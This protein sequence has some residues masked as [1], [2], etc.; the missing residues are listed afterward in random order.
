MRSSR[1]LLQTVLLTSL[2]NWGFAATFTVTTTADSGA[3]SLRQA[4]LDANA[5]VGVPDVI[6]F[7]IPPSDPGHVYYREDGQVGLPGGN[8]VT[9]TTE[10]DDANLD[11]PDQLYPRSWYRIAPVSPLPDIVD[12]VVIDGYTQ[13]GASPNSRTI[14]EGLNT[15]LRVELYG[16][17]AGFA[18]SGFILAPGSEGSTIRGFA[19]RDFSGSDGQPGQGILIASDNNTIEGNFLGPGVDGL[20]RSNNTHGIHTFASGNTI[21]G[22]TPAARNLISGNNRYGM[23]INVNSD[24]NTIAGNIVGLNR[25]GNG[26]GNFRDGVLIL[27]SPN[28]VIGG[29][30][31]GARNIISGNAWG[32]LAIVN[33]PATGN[34]VEGNFI[35]VNLAG[36]MEIR[37]SF[38]GVIC[39]DAPGNVIGGP[40]NGQGNVISGNGF[41]GVTLE[42]SNNCLIQ[43]NFIGTDQSGALAIPNGFSGV[44]VVD[45]SFSVIG[46]NGNGAN[47]IAFNTKDG[48]II[49]QNSL[50]NEISGNAIY[51]NGGL[52]I[53]L[54][55]VLGGNATA[56]GPTANDAGDFDAGPNNLQNFPVLTSA[57][58]NGGLSVTYSV[59][60]APANSVYPITVEFFVADTD[61]QEGRT[62]LGSDVYNSGGQKVAVLPLKGTVSPGAQILATATDADGNTSEFSAPVS[63]G[64][65]VTQRIFTVNSTGDSPDQNPLDGVCNTGNLVNGDPECTLCAA[66]QQAN[67]IANAGSDTPD[68]IHFAIPSNDPGHLYYTDDGIAGQ[69]TLSS[70]ATATVDS[71]GLIIGIDPDWSDSWY[72]IRLESPLPAIT[73]AVVIDGHTQAGAAANSNPA[74]QGL[75]GALRI[76]IDGSQAGEADEGL[77]RSSGGGAVIRGLVIN[78]A[79]GSAVQFDTAGGN[80]IEGCY[81]GPDISGTELFPPPDGPIRIIPRAGVRILSNENVVG[82]TSP[83]ARNLISGGRGHGV[84]IGDLGEAPMGNLVQGNLIGTDRTGT[85]A[86]PNNANG[87]TIERGAQN[88][89]GGETEGAGNLI[90]GNT[91]AGVHLGF[92][93]NSQV[94]ENEVK[95]NR[96][97]TTVNGDSALG[98][99]SDGILIEDA[100]MNRIDENRIAFNTGAG[101]LIENGS[102]NILTRNSLFSNGQIGIDL[103]NEVEL[104]RINLPQD[105]GDG[106]DGANNGQNFPWLESVTAIAG[107]VV[108]GRLNSAPSSSYRLEFFA[109]RGRD[110]LG[111]GEGEHY[112]GSLDVA[113][114]VSGNVEFT[115]NLPAAPEGFDFVSATATDLTDR[116][117]GPANDTSEFSGALPIGGCS[118]VVS[119]TADSG[120]G[121]LREAIYCANSLPDIQT[122]EFS[123][124]GAGPHLIKPQ[125]ALPAILDPVVI[126]GYTQ[127]GSSPNTNP[128]GQG[129]NTVLQVHIDGENAGD[130]ASGLRISGG[131][132]RIQGLSI[133]GFDD[134]GLHLSDHGGNV[135]AGSFL[136]ANPDGSGMGSETGVF[137][138]MSPNNV[139]GGSSAS[140]RN[141]ISGNGTGV[142]TD[143]GPSGDGVAGT[144]IEGNLI[145]TDASGAGPLGNGVGVLAGGS[146]VTV[147][148]NTVA[149]NLGAGIVVQPEMVRRPPSLE[150][151]IV[152]NSIYSNEEL[153]VDIE[154][155]GVTP[156]DY[157]PPHDADDGSNSRQNFPELLSR[158]DG[159]T[160]RIEGQ[161]RSTPNTNFRI[162]FF[163]NE[164]TDLT[165]F[166]EG[167]TFLTFLDVATDANGTAPIDFDLGVAVPV[168]RSVTST[169][170]RKDAQGMPIETSEFSSR[171]GGPDGCSLVV[172]NTNPSGDGSLRDA[173][174]CANLNAGLDT[175]TFNIPGPGPHTIRPTG[176]QPTILD[177]VIID[178][179]TQPGAAPNTDPDGFNGVVLIELDGSEAE[180]GSTGLIL[181][182]EGCIIRGLA[183]GGFIGEV[184]ISGEFIFGGAGIAIEGGS[185]CMIQGNLLGTDSTGLIARPNS[186]GAG[187][188]FQETG[189]KNL[190]GGTNPEDRNIISGNEFSGVLLQ[191]NNGVGAIVQGNFIGTDRTGRSPLGNGESAVF[192]NLDANN[193]IGGAEPGAGNVL[194]SSTFGGVDIGGLESTGNRVEGNFIGTDLSRT[195]SLGNQFGGVTVYDGATGN[196]IVANTISFNEEIGIDLDYDGVTLND[197]PPDSVPP[198]QDAGSNNLQNFPVISAVSSSAKTTTV[199]GIL[200]STP[201]TTFR[202]DFFTS[203]DCDPSGHGEGLIPLGSD[204]A[205]TDA[206]GFVSFDSVLG[207]LAATG[208]H[209]T[210][211]ATRMLEGGALSDTSEFSLCFEITDGVEPTPTPTPGDEPCPQPYPDFVVDQFIDAKDVI[212]LVRDLREKTGQRDLTGDALTDSSDLFKFSLSWQRAD[213]AD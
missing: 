67:A 21:G 160:T 123:V 130:F 110:P 33:A 106:D 9:V 64:G 90:S 6:I 176:D 143:G 157:G 179:Y 204:T 190:I 75:H 115:A 62:F 73:E 25:D 109:A 8:N 150:I 175:I 113:T 126:D 138:D 103:V 203:P 133:T 141:L 192:I 47:T 51:S 26:Q 60:S 199:Q 45:S 97:G 212:E 43:G 112:L 61:N 116:G 105:D 94:S 162:E 136:G 183:I 23:I 177:A 63:V 57:E 186:F 24:S 37:N 84:L 200:Q 125:S 131:G 108:E 39:L 34:V 58:L 41:G 122:I 95:G 79:D 40:D 80:R 55:T 161:L 154:E 158:I 169:A 48:V 81:V 167:Q 16:S 22:T 181:D 14:D 4:I 149:F 71:K 2:T 31:P 129:L 66:I 144:T 59:D 93:T 70:T 36:T 178:G 3:G 191:E 91:Q 184:D 164:T 151:A 156:N 159:A 99:G 165:G 85:V 163:S 46:G 174:R 100:E 134:F 188:F 142:E 139:I 128:V 121:S 11:N 30:T 29:T 88:R 132:S 166:G 209:L 44:L 124:P 193:L 92:F 148:G 207:S 68:R 15:I 98:N 111:F 114:D 182:A 19:I 196:S 87:A 206:E 197:I 117:S 52:G 194:A 119:T 76:E 210:S 5:T 195:R 18:A 172:T 120:P 54:S 135:V 102:G 201:N 147:A 83:A 107:T 198:D 96:V 27:D 7:N 32:G 168:E 101:I 118:L 208:D 211:T 69:V 180:I 13:P 185:G 104:L 17:A 49:S 153:G 86:V 82:G 20:G 187:V 65:E 53:D 140:E 173:I 202:L 89:I 213:C 170:T 38:H 12:P 152:G 171:I 28:N 205:T 72:S 155:D 74:G 10:A 145:G 1:I 42:R 77:L 35:G 50:A 56:D 189:E 78:R 146:K 137:V 127:P